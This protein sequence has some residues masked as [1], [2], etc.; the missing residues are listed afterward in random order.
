MRTKL[1]LNVTRGNKVE[2]RDLDLAFLYWMPDLGLASVIREMVGADAR[3]EKYSFQVPETA[4]FLMPLKNITMYLTF[5]DPETEAFLKGKTCLTNY[6]KNRI[7]S[8]MEGYPD[9]IYDRLEIVE[10]E[11]E[12]FIKFRSTL[13]EGEPLA[14]ARKKGNKKQSVKR[15]KADTGKGSVTENMA[16]PAFIPEVQPAG[17]EQNEFD[18]DDA[19]E[20]LMNLI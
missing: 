15:Q 1:T 18:D 13:D 3:K 14:P 5:S 20:L 4:G 9:Y 7:R 2:G 8:C 12:R 19:E 6:L 17:P 16:Q 10:I 11:G